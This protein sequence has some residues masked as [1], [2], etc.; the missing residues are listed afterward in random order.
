MNKKI[1]IILLLTVII[2]TCLGYYL[3]IRN[4]SKNEA[5]PPSTVN[6]VSTSP[7]ATTIRAPFKIS[8]LF[9]N[10]VRLTPFKSTNP[11]TGDV[12]TIQIANNQVQERISTY[13]VYVNKKLA[14]EFGGQSILSPSFSNDDKYFTFRVISACGATCYDTNIIVIN[15]A[16]AKLS[17]INTPQKEKDY[18]GEKSHIGY[19][20]NPIIES[21]VWGVGNKLNINFFFLALSYGET[22]KTVDYYRVSSKEVWSYDLTNSSYTLVQT[23]PETK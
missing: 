10:E 3:F 23:I 17:T 7:S 1:I 16:N 18:E 14:G 20:I 22:S 15:I 4:T 5:N 21:F 11:V 9:E 8:D 6:T 12:I 13:D 2:V 19:E